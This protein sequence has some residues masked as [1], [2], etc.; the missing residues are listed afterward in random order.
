MREDYT[1]HSIKPWIDK[2][3]TQVIWGIVYLFRKKRQ[4]W[5]GEIEKCNV[6]GGSV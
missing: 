1:K 5:A 2:L 3:D 6:Q 4:I